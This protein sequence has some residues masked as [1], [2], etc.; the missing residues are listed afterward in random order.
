MVNSQAPAHS[1]SLILLNFYLCEGENLAFWLNKFG[2]YSWKAL[3]QS[4]LHYF[5]FFGGWMEFMISLYCP[6]CKVTWVQARKH[7]AL[8]NTHVCVEGEQNYISKLA[9]LDWQNPVEV[10]DIGID[11]V[12]LELEGTL[13]TF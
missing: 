10:C 11:F 8:W 3:G 6:A 2:I 9:C 4:L 5:P 7:Q 12:T 13:E 1:Q